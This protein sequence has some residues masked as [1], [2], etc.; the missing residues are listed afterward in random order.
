MSTL[1]IRVTGP[2]ADKLAKELA[3][4]FAD[5]FGEEVVL[6]PEHAA[7][8]N[9]VRGD[10]VAV[11]AL[12]LSIPGAVLATIDLAERMKVAAK[13]RALQGWVRGRLES[14]QA[15]EI[16]GLGVEPKALTEAEVSE[17]VDAAIELKKSEVP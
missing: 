13:W 14:G 11:A 4:R 17:V 10:P 16:D 15:V 12:I 6:A 3:E 1:R 9:T 7:A 2:G 5:N 8:Q